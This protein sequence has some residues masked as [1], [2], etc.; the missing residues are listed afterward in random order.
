MSAI[1]TPTLTIA[2]Q[3]DIIA[4]AQGVYIELSGGSH[5]VANNPTSTAASSRVVARLSWLKLHVVG[6]TRYGQFI[7]DSAFS[8]YDS[9]VVS[10]GAS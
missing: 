7:Q 9:T 4:A 5:S 6:D 2:G 8:R 10:L 3:N 1:D